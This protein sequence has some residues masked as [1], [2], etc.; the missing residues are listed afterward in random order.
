MKCAKWQVE[1]RCK[2]ECAAGLSE[3]D[4][5]VRMI[6]L[7]THYD[8]V[9]PNFFCFCWFHLGTATFRERCVAEAYLT[10]ISTA[11]DVRWLR[12]VESIDFAVNST[13]WLL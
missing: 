2:A 5:S 1:Y 9:L 13:S 10:F 4:G 3:G 6:L 8:V 12:P 7:L 11:F